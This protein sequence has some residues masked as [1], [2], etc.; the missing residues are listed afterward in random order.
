MKVYIT[1]I[2]IY[3]Q[4]VYRADPVEVT[5]ELYKPYLERAMCDGEEV[6]AYSESREGADSLALAKLRDVARRLNEFLES[7]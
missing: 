4:N 7:A 6:R 3:D 5:P 1:E 2:N